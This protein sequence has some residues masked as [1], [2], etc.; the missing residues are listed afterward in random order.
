MDKKIKKIE[1]EMKELEHA[2]KKRDKVCAI[3]KK[4]MMNKK[5][6]KK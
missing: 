2:D 5:G 3:G 4:A 6:K 1:H